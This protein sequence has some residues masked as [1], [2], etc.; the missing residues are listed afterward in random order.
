DTSTA[1]CR[2]TPPAWREAIA[3]PGR[4][5]DSVQPELGGHRAE[6]A[7]AD[8]L[9]VRHRHRAERALELASPEVEEVVKRREGRGEVV[10]L[11]DI[12]LEERRMIRQGVEDFCCGQSVPVP[13]QGQV[14]FAH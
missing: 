13:L 12:G 10:G 1:T 4:R 3:V 14:D 2:M 8:E 5:P 7:G 11:P 9:L 6:L